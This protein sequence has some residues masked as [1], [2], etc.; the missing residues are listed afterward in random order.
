[1]T[2]T[3]LN[4]G[5]VTQISKLCE[6]H[7]YPNRLR[8]ILEAL[9]DAAR[10]EIP[11]LQA[12][13]LSGSVATGDF[14]WRESNGT[15]RLLSDIDVM[16][17]AERSGDCAAFSTRIEGLERAENS[18]LFHIDVSIS[19]VSALKHVPE[20]YQFVEAKHAGVAPIGPEAL[21]S[22]PLDFDLR[23]ARQSSIGNISMSVMAWVAPEA[24][25]DEGYR[26]SLARMILDLPILAFSEQ[27]R[28]IAGHGVRV[29][30]FL[31]LPESH[32]LAV[33][34]VRAAVEAAL[35]MRVKGDVARRELEDGA[36]L[37]IDA[38]LEFLDGRGPAGSADAALARRIG[39][40]LPARTPRRIAG[41]LR[42][43]LQD[44]GLWLRDPGW[45][46]RRKEAVGGAA[47]IGLLH[48][49]IA[50]MT[51][52][53]PSEVTAL[54]GNFTAGRKPEGVGKAYLAN[55]QRLYWE[56]R[57][58]LYPS[59]EHSQGRFS[60]SRRRSP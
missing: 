52:A 56:G 42:S 40:L 18:H 25:D 39:R 4:P 19:H 13:V 49:A 7:A 30:A 57:C 14:V 1:M 3:G 38:L 34:S 8:E 28:C 26:L 24:A 12:L 55:A 44:S 21:D 6:Q 60:A 48:Y 20:R 37:A 46:L 9:T 43:A 17:F 54:M 32:P 36:L 59:E 5:L 10:E 50:G 22:F 53:P 47:L 51:S 23:A 2:P 45:W 11:G 33:P 31:E 58:R 16:A 15:T 29:K 41:E 35:R 27:G